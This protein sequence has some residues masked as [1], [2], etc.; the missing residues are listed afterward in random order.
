MAQLLVESATPGCRIPSLRYAFF[1]GDKL[2][3]QDV[4][5]LRRL[6]PEVTCINSY[7]TTE[8]QRAVGY[9]EV[10]AQPEVHARQDK[11]VYPLGRG[12]QDVQLLVLTADQQLA[13]VG[14]LGE[15]YFRSPHLA[16]GYLAD[17][18]LT[19]ARFL[20]NPFTGLAGDRLYKTGDLGR[21]LADGNVEFAG[22][23]DN[24]VKIRGFRIEPGEIE[25]VLSQHPA[26]KEVVVVA[27][28]DE[29]DDPLRAR[30]RLVGYVVATQQPP[31]TSS[32]L[33]A[34]LQRKLPDYMIPSAFAFLESLPLTPNGKIDHGAL[35]APDQSRPEQ[36]NLFV[37][38]RTPV[39][40]RL[41]EI[42]REVLGVEP[43]GVNQRFFDL[44]GHSLLAVKVVSRILNAFNVELPLRELFEAATIAA[45]A[46]RIE[47]MLW[48]ATA[49]DHETIVQG[50]R[51]E[52]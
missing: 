4:S 18:A 21:Y 28:E 11:A 51:I 12:I 26:L 47:T 39:E 16:Q 42:W 48:A 43:I 50:E 14:E 7:G 2:T 23:A 10:T 40:E 17:Q 6:A 45:L 33:R 37:A 41:I 34:F 49:A 25:A 8:T 15:I 38:P 46:E 52:I 29:G 32:D 30:K 13:G 19:H 24:Q 20:T 3:R 27:R 5:R 9:F 31:P 1:V 35:P 22:R 44:G 36:E